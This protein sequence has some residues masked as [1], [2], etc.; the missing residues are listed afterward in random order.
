MKALF[1]LYSDADSFRTEI[2]LKVVQLPPFNSSHTARSTF[3][4][5]TFF[6]YRLLED[7]YVMKDP[8]T[9]DKEKILILGS[10]CS[11]CGL[12]VCVGAVSGNQNK[13]L[14]SLFVPA[15]VTYQRKSKQQKLKETIFKA[16]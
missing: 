9:P 13:L 12:S 6:S 11:L 1:I 8:F 2:L 16:G 3:E 7:C 10:L 14:Q 5:M 4:S 15:L